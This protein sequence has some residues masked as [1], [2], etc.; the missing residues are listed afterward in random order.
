MQ[1]L[2][3]ALAVFARRGL[4]GAHHAEIAEQAGVSVSTVFVY[5]P[6]REKLV[7][8]VLDEVERFL[9]DM[10]ERAHDSAEPAAEVFRTHL[11]AFAASVNTHRNHARVWLDWSTAIR[12][13]VWPRYMKFQE[14]IVRTLTA[15][16][17]RGQRE[18][19]VAP[20]V[21]P[22]GDARLIVAS[23]QMIAQ[24]TFTEQSEA[25]IDHFME[26]VL[27]AALGFRCATAAVIGCR[28]KVTSE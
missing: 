27:A 11:A 10:A 6:T 9:I 21:D 25:K 4:S 14:R 2:E 17:E 7:V 20:T 24:M 5:F 1:L 26:T 13:E 19:D 12:E 28:H 3:C 16:I 18:G 15:T 22:E 23:A 8:A